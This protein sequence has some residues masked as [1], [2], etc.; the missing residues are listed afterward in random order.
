ML[1]CCVNI[2]DILWLPFY[3]LE[4]EAPKIVSAN[5]TFVADRSVNVVRVLIGTKIYARKNS[6]IIIE[7]PVSGIPH[8]EV[9]DL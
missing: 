1:C 3:L 8:P 6:R 5:K 4:R 2:C 7:C 9:E